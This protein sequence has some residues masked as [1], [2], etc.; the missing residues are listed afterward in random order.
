MELPVSDDGT[1]EGSTEDQGGN[2]SGATPPA[3]NEWK[4]P[5]SQ[6]ELNRIIADRV[7]RTE[8]KYADAPELRKKAAEYDKLVDAQKTELQKIQDRA[9]AAE[10]RAAELEAAEQKRAADAE[11][12]RQVA[13]WKTQISKATG[14]PAGA[15]RGGTKEDLQAHA[16]ELKALIPDPNTRRVGGAYVPT[17]GRN[18]GTGGSD[19][20]E[21]FAAILKQARGL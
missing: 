1:P 6:E 4:P 5:A 14:I 7:K 12:A 15:L 16:E 11:T 10:R 17:E 9:E 2:T 13:D 3:G 19:P 18:V 8:A 21:Q 20:A